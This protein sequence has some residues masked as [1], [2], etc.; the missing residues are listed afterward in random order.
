MFDREIGTDRSKTGLV[1]PL[2]VELAHCPRLGAVRLMWPSSL[3]QLNE[4]EEAAGLIGQ[5]R[6]GDEELP[7]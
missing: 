3:G 7:G 2:L 1:F 4:A 6:A 5:S